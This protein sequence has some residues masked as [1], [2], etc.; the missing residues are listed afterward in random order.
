MLDL[1]GNA[2][3]VLIVWQRP[4]GCSEGTESCQCQR[5]LLSG[6]FDA[7]GERSARLIFRLHSSRIKRW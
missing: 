2:E 7:H 3:Q 5:E 1:H 4:S 6:E